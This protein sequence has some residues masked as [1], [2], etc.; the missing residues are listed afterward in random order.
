MLQLRRSCLGACRIRQLFLQKVTYGPN[1]GE[2]NY[3]TFQVWQSSNGLLPGLEAVLVPAAQALVTMPRTA[4]RLPR[5]QS[6]A[7][8]RHAL[9]MGKTLLRVLLK[10]NNLH[11]RHAT[12]D[13][14]DAEN[15]E[16]RATAVAMLA[17]PGAVGGPSQ[18][19]R[20]RHAHNA[21]MCLA[22]VCC[23]H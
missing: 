19:A 14:M 2:H 3:D 16:V 20:R 9:Q 5:S 8:C 15:E 23:C 10:H 1:R 21:C 4:L 13:T 7:C 12:R 6:P 17:E 18:E 22:P 11:V